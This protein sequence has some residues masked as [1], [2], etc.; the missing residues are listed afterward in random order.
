MGQSNGT[1]TTLAGVAVGHWT[2]AEGGTGCTT[3][4]FTPPATVAVD[5]RGSAPG[6]R[7]TDALAVTGLVGAID[8]VV[9]SG[10]SAFGLA[11][12]DG[13]VRWLEERG[14]GFPTPAGPVPVVPAAVIFDLMVGDATVRPGPEAGYAAASAASAS[15]VAAGN[16]GAGTGAVVGP[17]GRGT[18]GGLGSALRTA[19]SVTVGAMAVVNP[20]GNVHDP[21]TGRLLAGR[22]GP[23]GAVVAY[24]EQAGVAGQNTTLG[25]V[26]TNVRLDKIGVQNMARMAHDGL[27]RAIRPAH[28]TAD[29]DTVFAAS[30]GD[31]RAP[32]DLTLV[33]HLA[34]EALACAIVNAVVRAASA[35]GVPCAAELGTL[36]E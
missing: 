7:E 21:D 18:K 27:A 3:V 6:T 33:G 34:A 15:P 2:H 12:A 25:L 23:T 8:A 30:A 5:V 24:G 14:R 35:Y 4:I 11:A 31:Q 22:R 32:A 36:S 29:G 28:G 13:V 19:G 10:G 26:A 9:L 17:K 20:A 16:V 1:L